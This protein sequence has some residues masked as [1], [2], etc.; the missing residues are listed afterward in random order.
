[1]KHIWENAEAAKA[2]D[3]KDPTGDTEREIIKDKRKM[4]RELKTPKR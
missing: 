3:I 4:D 2:K 1:M